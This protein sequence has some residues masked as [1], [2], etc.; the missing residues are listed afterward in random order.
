MEKMESGGDW[1]SLQIQYLTPGSAMQKYK[2]RQHLLSNVFFGLEGPSN[3]V[4]VHLPAHRIQ[5]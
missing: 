4:P 1:F 3:V 5:I 2:A